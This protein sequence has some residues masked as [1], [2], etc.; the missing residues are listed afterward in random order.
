MTQQAQKLINHCKATKSKS[1][2]LGKCGLTEIP[3]EVFK[4]IW[5]EEL[6]LS[7]QYWVYG[8]GWFESKN[9]GKNNNLRKI[10]Q[11]IEKL[12][13]L[14][15]LRVN[16]TW[17]NKWAITDITALE[18]LTTLSEL[19]LSHNQI[20][21]ISSLAK[22]NQ[23][24]RLN[25]TNNQISDV[26]ALRIL[27]SLKKLFLSSNQISDCQPLSGLKNLTILGLVN[28]QISDIQSLVPLAQQSQLSFSVNQYP[29]QFEIRLD[30]NPLPNELKKAI[31]Q[32]TNAVI[33]YYESISIGDPKPLYAAK[34]LI[35]GEPGAGKTSLMRKL[36]NP[37]Y[38]LPT[39][40]KKNESTTG[41]NI[42][43]WPFDYPQADGGQFSAYIWDFGGQQ[44]QYLTHQFFLTPRSVYILLSD[45][46]KQHTHFPYWF[47][48]IQ[49]LGK[50]KYGNNGEGAYSPVIVA[51]NK[52]GQ[53]N[54]PSNFELSEY[55][56][57]FPDLDIDEQEMDLGFVNRADYQTLLHKIKEA[58]K[59][60][61]HLQEPFP[62]QWSAVQAKLEGL[63]QT[64]TFINLERYHALCY[65][66]EI[67]NKA[68]HLD[69]SRRLHDMGFILH[70]QE[71]IN[72]KDRIILSPTW[73]SDAVYA[74]LKDED[75]VK[76]KGFFSRTEAEKIWKSQD[77]ET[78][79]YETLMK[80][81]FQGNFEVCFEDKETPNQYIVPYLMK[82][83]PTENT[84]L[85]WDS[86]DTLRFRYH[87]PFLPLGITT[88]LLVRLSHLLEWENGKPV[89]GKSGFVLK[90]N[91]CQAKVWEQEKT[92]H[93]GI[94]VIDIE[95]KGNAGECKFLLR[96][97]RKEI[98]K[99]NTEQFNN[100][101]HF[102]KIPCNCQNINE[103]KQPRTYFDI[104]EDL[105]ESIKHGE[106]TIICKKHS[107]TKINIKKLLSNYDI[108]FTHKQHSFYGNFE[109]E[110]ART[111]AQST[112]GLT[113]S[114]TELVEVS[115]PKQTNVDTEPVEVSN[116][117]P[118][119][120]H[121]DTEL[122][123]V[124]NTKPKHTH[125]DTEPAEVSNTKSQHTHMDTEPAEVSNTKPKYTYADTEPVEVSS[126]K[127]KHT[128]MDTKPAEVPNTKPYYK[129]PWF[130]RLITS[131]TLG[132]LIGVLGLY[133]FQIP[134]FL[135]FL[136][137]SG[138]SLFFMYW[139]SSERRYWRVATSL[140]G[141]SSVLNILEI[142]VGGS[143][144]FLGNQI[145]YRLGWSEN[146]WITVSLIVLA[147]FLFYLDFKERNR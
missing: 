2:D 42:E 57:Q 98:E 89:A 63:S 69:I 113:P 103:S 106:F 73:A 115:N 139:F 128:H 27:N 104:E 135:T 5:L 17:K 39:R 119:H 120:T 59:N 37:K 110:P 125:M 30:G 62:V 13:Q 58:L 102:K 64:E 61:P 93:E 26:S 45:D 65:E 129:S 145:N 82:D 130:I 15:I 109:E 56:K 60:L 112:V 97:I 3:Q 36:L 83:T 100:V 134:F 12:Q 10:P 48:I 72:L 38:K 4:C 70:F 77:Y 74:L 21:D 68:T 54:M 144:N 117:K 143:A 20:K 34:L 133:Y 108:S 84:W 19:N 67:E 51:L 132:L 29:Q 107:F 136:A 140:V 50:D 123:E 85:Q 131:I 127:P 33:R 142:F 1:L 7:N 8:K 47:R 6:I 16:G 35:V 18:Q 92:N 118:K 32:G 22:L 121:A 41:I 147:G 99:I 91:G 80:M 75:I 53:Q 124:S 111:S 52:M 24:V 95:V 86:A 78:E 141:I 55:Q 90:Q 114:D 49:L 11:Q 146:P 28:N 87:Y 40:S 94:S 105:I 31:E 138:I 44:I 14:Q 81:L 23:L 137:V 88:R 25:L 46:R 43:T 66:E 101:K 96:D 76:R 9:E 126:T 116:P 71:D 79:E 122:A